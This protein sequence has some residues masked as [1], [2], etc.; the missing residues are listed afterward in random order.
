MNNSCLVHSNLLQNTPGGYPFEKF[1]CQCVGPP[2]SLQTIE[3]RDDT[4][5]P[6][7]TRS[8]PDLPAPSPLIHSTLAPPAAKPVTSTGKP[9]QC[10][11]CPKSFAR[12]QERDRHELTHVPYFLHCPL[13][14]CAWRGNRAELFEKHWQRQDHRGF[15]E[16]Y[17]HT[18][19]GNQIETYDPRAIL[20][21][22]ISC[23]I[24]LHEGEAQA[25][26][27][28]QVRAYELQKT[29]IWTDPWGRGRV[30]ASS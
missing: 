27:L 8:Q 7:Y 6:L 12:W 2:G 18:P 11:I 19:K 29:N 22:I 16:Y 4:E 13:P 28:V 9:W 15:H 1:F 23:A 21:Q 10:H 17:G 20:N 25:I 3:Q 14:H 30:Q 5:D 24:S 26:F